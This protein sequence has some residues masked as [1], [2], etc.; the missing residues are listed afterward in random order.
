MQLVSDQILNAQKGSSWIRRMFE[1]GIE[2]KKQ[3]GADKVYDFS[4]GSPD[5]KPPVTVIDALR[6]LADEVDVPAGL[7]YMP[8]A[9]YPAAREALARWTEAEQG[10]PVPASNIVI[11]VGAA[12]GLNCIFRAILAPGEEVI[13]PAPYFVEYGTYC[14]NYGGVLKTVPVKDST[15]ALDIDGIAAAITDKTRAI[16]INSP[17]NPSGAVY[18]AEELAALGE[19]LRCANV[20]RE[21][22]ILL[23]SDEPYRFLAYDGREVPSVLPF[24]E[25]SVICSSFSKNLGLAG[26]RIGYLAVNPAMGAEAS[27]QLTGALI[28]TNRILGYVNSP[29]IGQKLII[30]GLADVNL[31]QQLQKNQ[32]AVYEERRRAMASILTEA[33]IEFQMPA[34]TFYFFPKAPHG[35]NDIDFVARLAEHRVLAVPGTGFG[36]PGHFRLATCVDIKVIENARESIIAAAR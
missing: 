11:T 24:Y 28:L 1:A 8:N 25:Y 20:G 35:M 9:G 27:A 30:R 15:F 21:R 7:G 23:I 22:P 14:A 12:G 32:L 16:L 10:V 26:E 13:C 3:F 33:G 31:A 29:C 18:T 2:M 4:L 5:L 17:N 36:Y 6:Q 19:A 34:G